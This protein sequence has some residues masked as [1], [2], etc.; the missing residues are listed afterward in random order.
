MDFKAR[1]GVFEGV[2]LIMARNLIT[3]FKAFYERL[4][5]NPL[6]T[7]QIALCLAL[8]SINNRCTW[9]EWFTAPNITLELYTGLSRQAI[10]KNRNILK[11]LGYIDFRTNGTKAT[12]YKVNTMLNSLQDSL[13]VGLQDGLQSSLQDGLQDSLPLID[14]DKDIDKDINIAAVSNIY[15]SDLKIVTAAVEKEIC[16]VSSSIKDDI[17]FYLR[18]VDVDLILYAIDEA[19]K[20]NCHRWQYVSAII[21]RCIAD[22]I[23]TG[24]EAKRREEKWRGTGRSKGTSETD[25]SK[26]LT[27]GIRV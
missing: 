13:Q 12:S 5:V 14:K 10:F 18:S 20:S 26:Y 24:T 16:Q 6:S 3:E 23:L 25:Y 11:Q 7:G 9:Q 22:N 8:I 1:E 4:Q 17:E 2:K 27:D 21:K 15:N 19:T